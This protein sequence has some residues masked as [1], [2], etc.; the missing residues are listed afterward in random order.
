MDRRQLMRL[1]NLILDLMFEIVD[2]Q[3]TMEQKNHTRLVEI[4]N[5]HRVDDLFPNGMAENT[6]N[7]FELDSTTN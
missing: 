3:W 4:Y 2:S 5:H 1:I 6:D 7:E